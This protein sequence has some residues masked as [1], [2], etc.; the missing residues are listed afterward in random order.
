M[1]LRHMLPRGLGGTL[2]IHTVGEIAGMSLGSNRLRS[3]GGNPRARQTGQ[4]D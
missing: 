3:R 1:E 4:M 2:G